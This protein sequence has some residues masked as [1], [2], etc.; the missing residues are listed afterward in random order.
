MQKDQRK[1]DFW[2]SQDAAKSKAA[3]GKYNVPIMSGRKDHYHGPAAFGSTEGRFDRKVVKPKKLPPGPGDYEVDP[4]H[5][6][7]NNLKNT[8]NSVFNSKVEYHQGTLIINY[9]HLVQNLF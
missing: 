8:Y 7:S 5:L 9:C 2:I 3:P 6:V 4:L 1:T